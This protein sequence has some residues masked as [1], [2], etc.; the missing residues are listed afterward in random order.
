MPRCLPLLLFFA[1]S[2]VAIA[3]EGHDHHAGQTKSQL[4]KVSFSTTCTKG[5]RAEFESGVAML[6]SFWYEEA[7]KTFL[8]VAAKDATCAMAHWGIAMSVYH[9]L[10]GKTPDDS[11]R[12]GREQMALAAKLK[13]SPRERQY[14]YAIG[15]FYTDSVKL[16]PRARFLAYQNAME[17]LHQ[18]YPD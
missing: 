17:Q 13:A 4:G 16:D 18:K 7:E 10:W 1:F 11:L 2:S 9:P 6:H 15:A 8:D 5:V 12:R 14:L 3:D